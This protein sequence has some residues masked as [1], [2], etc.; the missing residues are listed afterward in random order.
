MLR[1]DLTGPSGSIW[2][3]QDWVTPLLSQDKG[4]AG[5]TEARLGH[6]A[7]AWSRA[8]SPWQ[9]FRWLLQILMLQEP[10]NKRS[11]W[12]GLC[13]SVSPSRPAREFGGFGG[14]AGRILALGPGNARKCQRAGDCPPLS[15]PPLSVP[16]V[17]PCVWE[18]DPC[19]FG[20]MGVAAGWDGCPHGGTLRN[21]RGV[22][23]SGSRGDTAR[24]PPQHTQGA[25]GKLR[26]RCLARGSGCVVSP[27]GCPL[28]PPRTF[29][30]ERGVS[31]ARLPCARRERWREGGD[32]QDTKSR[33]T[34]PCATLRTIPRVPLGVTQP[35]PRAGTGSCLSG[36]PPSS[37]G[38]GWGCEGEWV[39]PGLAGH[40]WASVA[41]MSRC[42]RAICWQRHR[43]L[44]PPQHPSAPSL[45]L[46]WGRRGL[47]VG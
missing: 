41:A 35:Q 40:G 10:K 36:V 26:Q 13:K 20:D 37:G 1:G 9:H 27:V 11:C 32:W 38:C 4:T 5:E 12:L 18:G 45:Q 23:S 30:T 33:G 25:V 17:Q 2:A 6:G 7:G 3:L 44:V 19:S 29:R 16:S 43:P 28:S 24:V 46:R 39:P 31:S 14:K 34:W 21:S 8:G 15:V 47:W 42:H 22:Q